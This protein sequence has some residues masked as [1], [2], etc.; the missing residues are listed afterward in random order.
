[1]TI[2]TKTPP[3]TKTTQ[4]KTP[5][6]KTGPARTRT[7]DTPARTDHRRTYPQLYTASRTPALVDVPP[8]PFLMID[9]RGDPNT[10]PEYAAAVQALYAVAYGVKFALRRADGTDVAVMP[11]QGL[12]SAPDMSDFTT[13]NKDAWDWT[14]MIMQPEAVTAE[15]VAQA[16]SAAAGK[17]PESA[18]ARLRLDV[19]P[20][21]P[22]AQV[23]HLGPYADEA[24]TI[25]ALHT[26]IKARGLRR[27]GRHHEIYLGDPRR[28]APQR[29]RTI[30]RQ[31]VA[32][33][34]PAAGAHVGSAGG[35]Q[36]PG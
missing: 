21:G 1:M 10:A 20:E 26:F 17:A 2:P 12:W 8:L 24:P 15:L 29:L 30:I 34:S 13:G 5:T 28:T 25:E 35:A 9:G 31:P 23:L 6:T 11:L 33:R 14:M 16:R 19:F 36:V 3:T 18:L 7:A 22:S 32:Q 4:A 27:R